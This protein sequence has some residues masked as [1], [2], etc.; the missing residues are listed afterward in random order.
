MAL[1]A[2]NAKLF[3]DAG[4]RI[5][6]I[7]TPE[8]VPLSVELATIS[9]RAGAFML[10]VLF[11]NVAVFLIV[12]AIFL[13]TKTGMSVT[14]IIGVM[15][16]V[17]FLIR[18]VYFLYFELMWRGATPGKRIVGLRVVDRHGGPLL[19]SAVIARNLTR[20]FEVFMPLAVL[21]S[22][23]VV[24]QGHWA[25]WLSAAWLLVI[26]AIPFLNRDHMRGGDLIAGTIVIALPRQLLLD[27]QA[28]DQFQYSFTHRELSAYGTYELQVLEEFLRS[29]TTTGRSKE[30]LSQIGQ[31][32][33]RKIGW[34]G[35]VPPEM[36][37]RFLRDFYTAERAFL[38]REQLFGT[39][40]QDKYDR[41]TT[42][43]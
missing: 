43:N 31:R 21:L 1:N 14:I 28:Q 19:P 27:D 12:S 25:P 37:D 7:V 42:Q 33:R 35:E 3:H 41:Q 8:A 38:E 40:R 36:E 22:V 34:E 29:A 10:D 18:N 4:R 39:L 13:L 23:G 2:P 30:I 24:A 16:L 9:E 6:E 32:I 26:G 11:W 15:S 20:E 17:G 5:R